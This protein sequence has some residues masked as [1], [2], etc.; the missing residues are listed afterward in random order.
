MVKK[1]LTCCLFAACIMS[2]TA[3]KSGES[4]ITQEIELLEPMNAKLETTYVTKMDISQVELYDGA[5]IPSM[6]E[7]SFDA[8]GYLYGVFVTPGQK[9]Y[10]GDVLAGLVGAD[11]QTIQNLEEEIKDLKDSREKVFSGYDTELEITKLNGGDVSEKELDTKQKKDL[12]DF[13]LKQKETRL[14]E[15]KKKDIGYVCITAPYDATVVAVSSAREN[16]Y[17][18]KGTAVVALDNGGDPLITCD[19]ISETA[20]SK[21]YTCYAQVR[22]QKLDLEYVPYTKNQLKIIV[23]NGVSPVSKFKINNLSDKE[24]YV[25]DYASVIVVK[26]FKENVLAIPQNAVYSDT[27][28]SFVYEIKNGERVRRSVTLGLSDNANVEIIDGLEEGACVY[29]KS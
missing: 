28:G 8:N 25:G 16:S 20:I 10:E 4:N 9:V 27:T 13:S 24:L 2:M 17:I 12:Y 23:N 15:L 5:V 21:I 11:Y 3:C 22:G 6:E 19:Y 1:F 29:V 14:E 7:F 26:N 18:P